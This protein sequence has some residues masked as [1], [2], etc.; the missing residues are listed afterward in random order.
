[1]FSDTHF[2]FKALCDSNP[3]FGAETLEG[4]AAEK[5]FFAMDI[6]TRSGDLLDRMDF[7]KECLNLVDAEKKSAVDNFFYFSAGIW[8]DV[9][10]IKNRTECIAVLEKQ[11]SDFLS[12]TEN[13]GR[14]V[15][16][17]ECG[18]DHHWNP[19]NP[20]ARNEND[21]SDE[22]YRGEC[23]LFLM[24]LEIA[25]RMS[26][27]VIIHSRD[28]FSETLSCL[29]EAGWHNGIIHCYSYG[30][31]EARKF[32]DRGWY[33][34]FGGGT[35]YTKKSRMEEMARLLNFVPSDRILLETDAPYLSPVPLRGKINTP[36]NI[37]HTY[38]FIA[39]QRGISVDELC[40]MVDENISRLFALPAR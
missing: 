20:D 2:H 9:G 23:E 13:K 12:A 6:G 21:F 25:K 31:D 10:E 28:A 15:A 29:D 33:I 40:S 5:P 11:I 3:S 19:S 7:Y 1:M 39:D 30:I 14:L 26:L 24:Q 16:I 32:L 22:I 36:L 38:R 18:L 35:T 8:P 27:P 37:P 17:G 34:A 4:Y